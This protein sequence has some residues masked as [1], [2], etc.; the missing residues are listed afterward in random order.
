MR[1]GIGIAM[2]LAIVALVAAVAWMALGPG[3]KAPGG[4]PRLF[5]GRP[6]AQ[7][8]AAAAGSQKLLLIK[9]TADWCPPCKEMDAT[10]FVDARVE[11]WV[12]QHAIAI[13][14]DIDKHEAIADE[15]QVEGI[16]TVVA[17]RGDARVSQTIGYQSADAFLSWLNGLEVK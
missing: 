1:Q 13:E 3:V 16:P 17:L 9:F 8:K 12:K 2:L 4:H 7:A 10:T 6:Y 15:F 14:V 5:D 11:E